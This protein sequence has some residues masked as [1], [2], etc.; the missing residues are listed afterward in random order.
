MKYILHFI[1]LVL[2]TSCNLN[3]DDNNKNFTAEN[4]AEILAYIE[5][6]NLDAKKTA[7]GLYIVTKNIGTGKQPTRAN[8]VTVAY[9][10]YF[11]NNR[12][13][14]ES[15]NGVSFNLSQVIAGWQEG[16]T[17]FK[18]GGSGILLIPSRLAYGNAGTR[19]IPGGSVILFDINLI[20]VN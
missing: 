13:F 16:I 15:A 7:S 8:N 14:D 17:N 19:G 20:S 4:E 1:V 10:G 18:E 6:N 2:L 12:T 9:R 5:A 3:D 11:T